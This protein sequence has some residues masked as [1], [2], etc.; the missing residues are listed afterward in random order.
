MNSPRCK[1][2]C[3]FHLSQKVP[4]KGEVLKIISEIIRSLTRGGFDYG[5]AWLYMN[6]EPAHK[7]YMQ[8]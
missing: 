8:S 6:M 7:R 4:Y 3:V 2:L 1:V 5:S